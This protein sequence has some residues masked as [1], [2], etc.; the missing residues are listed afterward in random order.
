M[1]GLPD[2]YT[3]GV[4]INKQ[5]TNSKTRRLVKQKNRRR[6]P[7]GGREEQWPP[8]VDARAARLRAKPVAACWQWLGSTGSIWNLGTCV[9]LT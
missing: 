2:F 1:Y 6:G 9:S 7:E 3:R 4:T 5:S 8:P